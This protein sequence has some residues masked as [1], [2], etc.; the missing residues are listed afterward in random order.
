MSGA[1]KLTGYF[2]PQVDATRFHTKIVITTDTLKKERDW[3]NKWSA[4]KHVT[5]NQKT[6]KIDGQGW[7]GRRLLE[8]K[9]SID[10]RI[11]K[12]GNF[13]AYD[14]RSLYWATKNESDENKL[15]ACSYHPE[16]GDTRP[17]IT[18]SNRCTS[19]AVVRALILHEFI[20]I[21]INVVFVYG[22]TW[23]LSDPHNT[24]CDYV[25]NFP[26]EDATETTK[27]M[28]N[29]MRSYLELSFIARKLREMNSTDATYLKNVT[30]VRELI[31]NELF[32]PGYYEDYTPNGYKNTQKSGIADYFSKAIPLGIRWDQLSLNG[33]Y[34]LQGRRG[35]LSITLH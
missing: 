17:T 16:R 1:Q 14:G 18:I 29:I 30:D 22:Y 12:G 31:R 10:E 20:E 13:K 2:A 8:I 19:S 28:K 21:Y 3:L 27:R 9:N 6:M 7:W 11:K 35:N 24:A 4:S 32:I 34:T 23:N 33:T 25:K 26:R 15:G 5:Y